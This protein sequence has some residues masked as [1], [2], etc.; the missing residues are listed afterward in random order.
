MQAVMQTLTTP[1]STALPFTESFAFQHNEL[2]EFDAASFQAWVDEM[3]PQAANL[4]PCTGDN[5]DVSGG[6]VELGNFKLMRRTL[7]KT[8]MQTHSSLGG[9]FPSRLKKP[10]ERRSTLKIY[11]GAKAGQVQFSDDVHIPV[12][13]QPQGDRW[14][15]WMSLTPMEIATCRGGVRKAFGRV[16]LGGLGL[17][18]MAQRIAERKQVERVTIVESNLD[19]LQF[20]GQPLVEKFGANRVQLVHADVWKYIADRNYDCYD[21]Y[22]MDV[23]SSYGQ[24]EYYPPFCDLKAECQKAGKR[25]WGWGDVKHLPE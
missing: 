5:P 20:F 2:I 25:V 18:W 8:F 14:K 11:Q 21:S 19:V 6:T 13:A 23:W 17:G 15:V 9:F 4:K 3:L 1:K 24:A 16:L 12:L 22:I 10:I 7:P